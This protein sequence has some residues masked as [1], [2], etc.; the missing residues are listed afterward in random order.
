MTRNKIAKWIAVLIVCVGVMSFIGR[1]QQMAA[2]EKPVMSAYGRYQIVINPNARADTF[3]LDTET[4]KVW[5]STAFTNIK[6]E[7][8]VWLFEDRIDNQQANLEWINQQTFKAS[9][10]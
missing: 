8:T 7:P 9:P 4:G 3:L 5:V 10:K 6:G 2:K 1:A